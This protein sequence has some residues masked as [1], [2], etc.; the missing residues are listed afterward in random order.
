MRP[1]YFS[2]ICPVK[3]LKVGICFFT[4]CGGWFEKGL[5]F[6]FGVL[7]AFKKRIL[8]SAMGLKK[9]SV[10]LLLDRRLKKKVVFGF[11]LYTCVVV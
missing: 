3:L 1:V 7:C 6:S 4:L 2:G 8:S 10:F 11:C 5:Y 9:E